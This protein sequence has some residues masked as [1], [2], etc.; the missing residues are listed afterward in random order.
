MHRRTV[1]RAAA[2]GLTSGMVADIRPLFARDDSHD[3]VEIAYGALNAARHH[4]GY[5]GLGLNAQLEVLA[6]A[7][8]AHLQSLGRVSHMDAQGRSPD[9]RAAHGSYQG[10][11]LGEALAE[12]HDPSADVVAHWLGAPETRAVVL[13]PQASDMGLAVRHGPGNRL[14]WVAI[15]AVPQFGTSQNI[16]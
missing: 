7:H 11:V 15:L 2:I 13:D 9:Q 6:Q 4:A 14:W 10:V 3:A 8:T 12:V 5:T 1:L 16:P